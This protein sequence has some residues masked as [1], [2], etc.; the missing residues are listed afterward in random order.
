[1]IDT[2]KRNKVATF[3]L[4]VKPNKSKSTSSETVKSMSKKLAKAQRDVDIARSWG[5]P[6]DEIL[7]YHQV[8]NPL[9]DGDQLSKPSKSKMVTEI[10]KLLQPDYWKFEKCTHEE[11]AIIVDFMSTI[12]KVDSRKT[13]SFKDV[14]Q[15]GW[16][17]AIH[18]YVLML[19]EQ[20]FVN[21]SL[22]HW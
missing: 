22:L 10:E 8:Q 18:G 14:F 3:S 21:A 12:C 19:M 5:I 4:K 11:T 1:M 17:T 6:L 16:N 15:H 13:S 7:A 2:I 9:F 20:K